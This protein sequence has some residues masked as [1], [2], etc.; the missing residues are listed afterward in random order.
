MAH[1]ILLLKSF[2][3]YNLFLDRYPKKK[4]YQQI[5]VGEFWIVDPA[6]KTLE[7][8]RHG[9]ADVDTP[10]LFLAEEGEVTSTVLP[11]LRFNLQDIF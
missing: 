9:Q 5:G 6:N 10:S 8:Y 11:E 4:I 7:I 2:P 1:P 3:P